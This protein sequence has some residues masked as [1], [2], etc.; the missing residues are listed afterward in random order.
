MKIKYIYLTGLCLFG[1][2]AMISDS[3]LPLLVYAFA[4]IVLNQYTMAETLE[5]LK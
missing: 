3:L 5:K 2:L 4:I 1:V